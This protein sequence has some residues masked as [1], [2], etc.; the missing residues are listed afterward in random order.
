[1]PDRVNPL[2]AAVDQ[3]ITEHLVQ[4]DGALEHALESSVAAGLPEIAVS[5]NQGKLLHLLA[6][7][8]RARA[9]LEI[10]TLG[11]YS[12]I[13]LARALEKGGRVISLELDPKH[14]IVAQENVARARLTHMVDVHVG[15]ALDLLPTLEGPFDMIFID[16]DKP[17]IPAYF[18]WA[19]KLARPGALIVVDNVIRE[20]AVADA[21]SVDPSVLGV[22]RLNEM[23]AGDSR[24]EATT[25]QTVGSKG[26]DGLTLALV[27]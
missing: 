2:W 17:N 21:S 22:R 11:G 7:M 12:T 20:G 1:M 14:A 8:L 6:R 10:G 27:C 5:P 26:Y 15:A 25:I 18:E 9:I 23:I 13:W 16:A 19:V 4:P 24:V 3:Y